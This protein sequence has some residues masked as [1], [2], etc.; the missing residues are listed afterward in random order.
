MNTCC[1]CAEA[2]VRETQLCEVHYR[3]ALDRVA[4]RSPSIPGAGRPRP[5]P[6]PLPPSCPPDPSEILAGRGLRA[7]VRAAHMARWVH[8]VGVPVRR[9]DA[10]RACGV[11][12]MN[13]VARKI[14]RFAE[15]EGW[16]VR[17]HRGAILPGPVAPPDKLTA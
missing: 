9:A 10:C 8:A 14:L 16:I 4:G 17:S 11:E 12:P 15:D 2:R 13:G 7:E 5:K 1:E 6:P 3:E